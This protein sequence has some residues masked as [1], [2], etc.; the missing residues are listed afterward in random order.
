MTAFGAMI[1][2]MSPDKR[3][4]CKNIVGGNTDGKTIGPREAML[5]K[6]LNYLETCHGHQ[7]Y[8][9]SVSSIM[10]EPVVGSK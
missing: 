6:K 5:S 1:V 7:G 9:A 10:V 4:I 2:A 3:E 8:P